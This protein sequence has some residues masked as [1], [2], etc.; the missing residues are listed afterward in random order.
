MVFCDVGQGDGFLIVTSGGKQ[1]L[2]DGGVGKRVETCLAGNMPFWDRTIEMMVPTHFQKDHM[3]GQIDVFKNYAVENVVTTKVTGSSTLAIEWNKGLADDR[4]TVHVPKAGEKIVVDDVVFEV[5]WPTDSA[6]AEW[7]ANEPSDLN[8]TSV[9]LKMVWQGKEGRKCAYFTGDVPKETLVEVINEPC[10]LLKVAHHG[11]KTGTSEEV[12][13]KI[14][15]KIAVIQV[16]KNSYGHPT[17]EVLDLLANHNVRI[18]RNDES[19]AIAFDQNLRI[20]SE[21]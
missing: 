11:S 18:L 16:G 3:E 14:N 19:G 4:S 2:I 6:Y 15:P 20:T 21:R 8:I 7:R 17:G 13:A 12:L 9:V 1:I 5:I 10:D